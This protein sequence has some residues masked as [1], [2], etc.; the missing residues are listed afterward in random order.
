MNCGTCG[1]WDLK[2]SPLRAHGFGRCLVDPNEA[3]R[4]GRT[5]SATNICRIGMFVKA[6]AK[7]IARREKE[8]A[9]IL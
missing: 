8:Q 4:A 6:E 7:V 1:N 3:M 2:N 9:V 5:F